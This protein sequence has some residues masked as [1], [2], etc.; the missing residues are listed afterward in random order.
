MDS[1]RWET[2]TRRE[3]SQDQPSLLNEYTVA[4]DQLINKALKKVDLK[5]LQSGNYSGSGGGS[6]VRSDMTCQKC[7]KE[8]HIKKDFRS[9]GNG[10]GG[11]LTKKSSN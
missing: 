11:N 1:K 4:I 9:K 2:S 10:S 7:G 6:Y 8:G 5:S 3:K